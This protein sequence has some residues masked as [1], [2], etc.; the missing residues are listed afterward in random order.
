ML[1]TLGVKDARRWW[2]DASRP[3]HNRFGYVREADGSAH[4]RH[5]P[6]ETRWK[7]PT[8]R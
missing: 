5:I 8:H 1:A 2:N 7:I 6:D 3:S 4:V